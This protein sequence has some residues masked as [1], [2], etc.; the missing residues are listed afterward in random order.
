MPGRSPRPSHRPG[1]VASSV[2]SSR[3]GALAPSVA[4]GVADGVAVV[5]VRLSDGAFT[6]LPAAALTLM[7]A[8]LKPSLP[9]PIETWPGAIGLSLRRT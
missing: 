6:D 8:G 3:G 9:A 1:R 2:A 4:D 7:A 5:D